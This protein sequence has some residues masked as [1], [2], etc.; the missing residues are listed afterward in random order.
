SLAPQVSD[1]DGSPL[2]AVLEQE[3]YN[4]HQV[5]AGL[6]EEIQASSEETR[7][8]QEEFN[9][10]TVELKRQTEAYH[11]A[12]ALND[13]FTEREALQGH[14]I[15]LEKQAP[16]FSEKQKIRDAAK[17]AKHIQV[18]DEQYEALS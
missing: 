4:V 7:Q 5:L 15:E 8:Q 16:L 14:L 12:K 6:E 9:L 3:H 1:R 17:Q 18:Y 2:K 10:Q 11:A 13:R